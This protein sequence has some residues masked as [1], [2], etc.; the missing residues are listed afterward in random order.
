MKTDNTE[1]YES[2]PIR[3]AVIKLAL[4]TIISQLITV[5]YNMADTFFIGQM[6]DP[7]QVAAATLA[8]PAFVLLTGIANLFGIGGASLISRYLGKGDRDKAKNCAAFSIYGAGTVAIIYG[9]FI[10]IFRPVIL[11]ILGTNAST[12]DFCY[13]YLFWTITVGAF[14]TV[15]SATLAHLVRSE[16]YS[17]QSSIGIAIGG[18]LNMILDPIFIFGFNM[19]IEGAAIATMLSNCVSTCYFLLFIYKIRKNS[20]ISPS[21]KNFTLKYGIPFETLTVGFPSFMTMAMGIVSNT[22]LNRLVSSYSSEAIAGMGIAKKIDM[23][24][25]AIAN[26]MTQGVLSLIAYNY[27]SGNRK[28]MNSAIKTTFIYTLLLAVLGSV[29]LFT[30]AAPV[31]KFFIDNK[32]TVEFGQYFLRVICLTCP[33]ISATF[34]IITVFQATGRKIQPMI[35]SLIRKGGFDIPFM[36]LLNHFFKA[37]GI[38]WATPI[39]DILAMTVAICLYV[40]FIKKLNNAKKRTP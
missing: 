3:K 29:F 38:A 19:K 34:I 25:F 8:M 28:R 39:S 31:S 21:P 4:P 22:V 7:N 27:A 32:E 23:L 20:V 6:N 1:L 24:A 36:F 37:Y 35:L 33:T 16:G 11:P 40:P 10:M 9:L 13:K 14:P 30:C 26:G 15:L 17:R 12:Y 18:I 2:M 5:L